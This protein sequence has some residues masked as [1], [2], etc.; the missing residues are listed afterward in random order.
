MKKI[1]LAIAFTVFSLNCA[2]A[3]FGAQL[4]YGAYEAS[5]NDFSNIDKMSNVVRKSYS[6]DSNC[7]GVIL[8]Y[9]HPYGEEKKKRVGAEIGY[10]KYSDMSMDVLTNAYLQIKSKS[11]AYSIPISLYYKYQPAKIFAFRFSGG[12]NYIFHS[13]DTDFNSG[14]VSNKITNTAIDITAST[15]FEFYVLK[16][17]SLGLDLGYSWGQLFSN[18]DVRFD[19]R[20]G[21]ESKLFREIGGSSVRISAR[22]YL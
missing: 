14:L 1:V 20:R 16:N 2:Y 13:W 19:F 17:V 7:F 4:E 12:I 15:G 10:R 11:A 3:K 18:D 6:D 21:A 9:E 8:F 5:H 22:V